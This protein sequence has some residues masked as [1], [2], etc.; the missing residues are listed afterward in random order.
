MPA[1]AQDRLLALG[2]LGLSLALLVGF[3]AFP[4]LEQPQRSRELEESRALLAALEAQVAR[5]STTPGAS[6]ADPARLLLSGET[7]GIAGAGLQKMLNDVVADANGTA[8]SYQLLPPEEAGGLERRSLSLLVSI[9]IAGLRTLLHRIETGL[10]L[11][12]V[13]DVTMRVPHAASGEA[14][15]DAGGPIEVTLQVS[16]FAPK[17][18]ALRP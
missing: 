4:F 16:G 5:R 13:D 9:D 18:G 2:L 14:R 1:S 11:L 15:T 8:S 7:T 10:P 6:L 12:F 3:A 17:S